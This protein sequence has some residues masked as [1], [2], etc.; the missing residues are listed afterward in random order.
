MT[1]W[2]RSKSVLKHERQPGEATTWSEFVAQRQQTTKP[3]FAR[4]DDTAANTKLLNTEK[5]LPENS[6]LSVKKKLLSMD[7]VGAEA[8]THRGGAAGD[9]FH[10]KKAAAVSSNKPSQ[11]VVGNSSNLQAKGKNAPKRKEVAVHD[12]EAE[13][14]KKLMLKHRKT[15]A[16]IL[17]AQ[18]TMGATSKKRLAIAPAPRSSTVN[19]AS[20]T[21]STLPR[22]VVKEGSQS[23]K[24][25]ACLPKANISAAEIA[26]PA[27]K[28]KLSP[29]T[30]TKKY[31]DE[32][33]AQS[34]AQVSK[35]RRK[36][37]IAK[38][39]LPSFKEEGSSVSER[40]GRAGKRKGLGRKGRA[41]VTNEEA[42][43]VDEDKEDGNSEGEEEQPVSKVPRTGLHV[44]GGGSG[45]AKRLQWMRQEREAKGLLLLPEKVERRIYLTKKAMRKK[46]LPGEQIKEAVRKMRRK[47]ELLFRRQLAKLCFK[48]RQ[49]GH[50]VSDC[51]QMLQDSSEPIGICFKCGS[52]EHFSSACTV[53]TSKDNEFPYAKCFICKQQGHLSRKCPR[54]DKGVYPKGGH[55][56]FCGAIDHFKKEC[57]EMEKNKSKTSEESEVAADIVSIG[58]SADAEN[59]VPLH[60]SIQL[61][62]EKVVSF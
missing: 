27:S 17:V 60:Q 6:N 3:R 32:K 18:K 58:Q 62:K 16:D 26:V 21:G 31:S 30:V 47:E 57:P 56:N 8:S 43:H 25:K 7:S 41:A 24:K 48:C 10:L 29:S 49:P 50:R 44:D 51:P 38:K 35:A 1:R 55:C 39:L 40:S 37:V 12:D 19:A 15:D 36:K 9:V 61:K 54:N 28:N 20:S 34:S 22:K 45:K 5:K 46:G 23:L 52:T 53:Q 11:H 33:E 59:I 14:L 13:A 4:P 2:A 42:L